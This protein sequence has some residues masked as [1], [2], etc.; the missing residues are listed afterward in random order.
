[1]SSSLELSTVIFAALK[2]STSSTVEALPTGIGSEAGDGPCRGAISACAHVPYAAIAPLCQSKF[3][4][5]NGRSTCS[6]R[7]DPGRA[8]MPGPLSNTWLHEP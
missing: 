7:A 6:L 3:G 5:N 1:M 4:R 2:I 8:R